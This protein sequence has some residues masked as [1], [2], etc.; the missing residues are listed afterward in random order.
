MQH[1]Y[2]GL[3]LALAPC[4]FL[5]EG[6]PS[7]NAIVR[8]LF[9][10]C[11]VMG[12]MSYLASVFKPCRQI[13][14]HLAMLAGN[15]GAVLISIDW[16]GSAWSWVMLLLLKMCWIIIM[17]QI[18]DFSCRSRHA[19]LIYAV[20]SMVGVYVA[21]SAG[22]GLVDTH[23]VTH[24]LVVTS[25][26]ALCV[27]VAAIYLLFRSDPKL[28]KYSVLMT[29]RLRGQTTLREN[30]VEP[31]PLGVLWQLQDERQ[32]CYYE[33][34]TLDGFPRGE[35]GAIDAL[36]EDDWSGE[37][38]ECDVVEG[39]LPPAPRRAGHGDVHRR[40]SCMSDAFAALLTL[41]E[42]AGGY[43]AALL[44]FLQPAESSQVVSSILA[45][46]IRSDLSRNIAAYLEQPA[47][48]AATCAEEDVPDTE[49]YKVRR[50][51]FVQDEDFGRVLI[52][53]VDLDVRVDT[54]R[55]HAAADAEI[56]F[57]PARDDSDGSEYSF[58][59]LI[60]GEP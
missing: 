10:G 2:V 36:A 34:F 12:S 18:F 20:A 56:V 46:R 23:S 6:A 48:A 22:R 52:E 11:C 17:S 27:I 5:Y 40:Y 50:E 29:S 59:E 24:G 49:V 51:M 58:D 32:K 43:G 19:H 26:S 14:Y 60:F 28:Q 54:P 38:V 42:R 47:S 41:P 9:D 57:S 15:T 16:G 53:H 44:S 7:N 31:V 21:G 45:A 8:H 1:P 35:L 13:A 39:N 4:I 37:E 25:N 55:Q 3:V 33:D 30:Q